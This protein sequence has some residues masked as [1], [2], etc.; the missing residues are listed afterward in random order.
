MNVEQFNEQL[1]KLLDA[2]TAKAVL[3]ETIEPHRLVACGEPADDENATIHSL[4]VPDFVAR[5]GFAVRAVTSD[6][7]R[8]FT[9]EETALILEALGYQ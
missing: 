5:L 3:L 2:D 6:P 7:E 9:D 1:S 4:S 8:V